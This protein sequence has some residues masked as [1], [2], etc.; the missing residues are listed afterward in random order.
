MKQILIYLSVQEAY[1]N[2]FQ[3]QQELDKQKSNE[4]IKTRQNDQ[5]KEA[6]G[7]DRFRCAQIRAWNLLSPSQ[8]GAKQ[9]QNGNDSRKTLSLIRVECF[10][11]ERW[12][13]VAACCH[14]RSGISSLNKL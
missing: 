3:M 14:F 7:L 13:L 12:L 9:N 2:S 8:K 1:K 11:S 4:S 5:L 6:P 10:S